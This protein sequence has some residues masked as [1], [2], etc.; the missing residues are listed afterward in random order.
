[1]PFL[2]EVEKAKF[3]LGIEFDLKEKQ[4]ETLKYLFNGRDCISVLPTSNEKKCY[5]STLDPGY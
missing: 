5:F 4:L 2:C 3:Q 1:M